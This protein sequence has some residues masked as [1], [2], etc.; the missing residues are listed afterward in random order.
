M[1]LRS[2]PPRKRTTT[3]LPGST[4]VTTPSPKE[5]WT[6]SSPTV[7]SRAAPLAAVNVKVEM[8]ISNA[9]ADTKSS[10][11]IYISLQQ[12]GAVYIGDNRIPSIYEVGD[13]LERDVPVEKRETT[14]LM[15]RADAGVAYKWVPELMNRLRDG[16][17]YKISLV[18]L[19]SVNK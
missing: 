18:G 5:A 9:N 15:L 3:T 8:P 17:C 6:T 19:E 11:P 12:T 13:R 2:S 7:S 10:S 4:A 1:S 16:G 14:K